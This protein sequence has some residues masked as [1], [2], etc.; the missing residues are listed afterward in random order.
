MRDLEKGSMRA[1][2]FQKTTGTLHLGFTDVIGTGRPTPGQ[3]R[4]SI[5][6]S[7][8]NGHDLNIARAI[9]PVAEGRVLL[10][11]AAGIVEE[12]GEGVT[13]FVAG[14]RV[15]SAFFP[16]WHDGSAPVV[17]F[18]RTPG[19]GLDGYGTD[20]VVRP[21][22]YFTRAPEGWSFLE[23]ATLPT[24]GLTAWRALV[25]EGRLIAGEDVLL[26]GTGGVS[27]LAL[28]MAKRM[29]AR[30]FI[31]SSSSEKLNRAKQLGADFTINY[32]DQENWGPVIRDLTGGRGVDLVVETGGPGTLPK[33]ID[34]AGIGAR[35][36]LVGVVTGIAGTV[37]TA[38]VMGKQQRIYGITVGSRK[39]QIDMV[40]GLEGLGI[41]PVIDQVFPLTDLRQAFE[42]QMAS[43]HFGKISIEYR[44]SEQ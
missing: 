32:R 29:G 33:S 10:T 6:A 20:A 27:I 19:D 25:L 35:I 1:V 44:V 26:I 16:D 41:K 37:P 23:A 42:A 13:E 9:L 31:T 14:D 40:R 28:K 30:V 38:A 15:I 7:S 18:S 43:K 5:Y 39:Q 12:V 34:A 21:A 4:V 17:G 11:D 24:A 22:H 2:T 8:L 36:V 3:V